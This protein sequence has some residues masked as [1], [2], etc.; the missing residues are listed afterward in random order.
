MVVSSITSEVT[1]SQT[2]KSEE[3]IST[4]PA[5]Q[6]PAST[7]NTFSVLRKEIQSLREL[8]LSFHSE[9]FKHCKYL[10]EYNATL[11][12]ATEV[13]AVSSETSTE[14]RMDKMETTF[15]TSTKPFPVS[16]ITE[17]GLGDTETILETS[18]KPVNLSDAGFLLKLAS[19]VAFVPAKVASLEKLFNATLWSGN[20]TSDDE[21]LPDELEE[22]LA[23][24]SP[25]ERE[26]F[27]SLS[28]EEKE[29]MIDYYYH[30]HPEASEEEPPIFVPE[31]PVTSPSEGPDQFPTEVIEWVVEDEEPSKVWEFSKELASNVA[32][33]PKKMLFGTTAAPEVT[34]DKD[35]SLS[36]LVESTT[37][38]VTEPTESSTTENI[39]FNIEESST[40]NTE[41]S[42]M[43]VPSLEALET[44]TVYS[45]TESTTD[46]SFLQRALEED[47]DSTETSQTTEVTS[48][49]T[50]TAIVFSVTSEDE[51]YLHDDISGPESQSSHT[52]TTPAL[53][54]TE[55]L[56]VVIDD[57]PES[58][59]ASAPVR[60]TTETLFVVIDDQSESTT[61]SAPVRETT[62][63]LL[64]V[65]DDHSESTTAPAP[66]RE[67]TETLFVIENENER[68]DRD[69]VF[70]PS[71][72][73]EPTTRMTTTG[74]STEGGVVFD[75]S[76]EEE[77]EL[78]A[79]VPPEE[80]DLLLSMIADEKTT[81]LPVTTTAS[82]LST[83]S[84]T[85]SSLTSTASE[86]VERLPVAEKARRPCVTVG[87]PVVRAGCV[88]PFVYQ[89]RSYNSCTAV[90]TR[91]RPWCST[92]RDSRGRYIRGQY[93]ADPH[94]FLVAKATLE[95]EGHGH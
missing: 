57:L 34:T 32:A 21:K 11:L 19:K 64:V 67:T 79:T 35:E 28:A 60:E 74:A 41:T 5:A 78:M 2:E 66:V 20:F 71:T 17:S 18:P 52:T 51:D 76:E 73:E 15:E 6:R 93:Q 39:L 81:E 63:T 53:E 50:T 49:E 91:G 89:R 82:T 94:G 84:S 29:Q 72:T 59:T 38:T 83:P 58:T 70:Y 46:V 26:V 61:A 23:N 16:L 33:I 10:E 4:S 13:P 65:I 75:I 54:T 43:V 90:H 37:E 77:D 44:S 56:F 48:P 92:R 7:V 9:D 27:L 3:S 47:Y 45:E 42:E 62:E 55:T 85:S 87:G 80:I 69:L 8:V 12:N 30:K 36:F 14:S 95:V 24:L 40:D 68:E 25:E 88:F 22:V 86:A 1:F 31:N